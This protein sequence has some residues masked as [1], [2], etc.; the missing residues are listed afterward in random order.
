MQ[1]NKQQNPHRML[2]D[3]RKNAVADGLYK[4]V[5]LLLLLRIGL[6]VAKKAQIR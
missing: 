5:L 1:Y 3:N 4:Y 2:Q 6:M